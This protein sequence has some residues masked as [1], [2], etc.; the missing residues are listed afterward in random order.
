[1]E[2]KYLAYIG[3]WGMK[4]GSGDYGIT[5]CVYDPAD[6]SLTA[7]GSVLPE[8]H[9]GN[10]YIDQE[11]KIL[12]CVDEQMKHED[13]HGLGGGGKLFAVKIEN[14][15]NL[16]EINHTYSFAPLPSYVTIDSRRKY[17]LLTNHSGGDPITVAEKDAEGNFHP[18]LHYSDASL[19]LYRLNEDGSVGPA[20]DIFKATG[21]GILPKQSMPHLHSVSESAEMKLFFV[22]DKGCNKVYSFKIQNDQLIKC[23]EYADQEGSAPRYGLVLEKQNLF[24]YNHEASTEVTI[25]RFDE[26][27]SL[28]FVESVP[29]LPENS[30]D[31]KKKVLISKDLLTEKHFTT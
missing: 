23:D 30:S 31:E 4:P 8:V 19:V 6:G 3:N 21:H 29:L 22:C 1:M 18:V 12:Y 28:S 17:A 11:R 20:I 15:G 5:A 13:F 10:V 26:N 7:T 9:V 25:L 14:D 2:N 27:G 24:L 16:R